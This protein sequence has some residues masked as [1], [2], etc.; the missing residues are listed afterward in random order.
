MKIEY[1][2]SLYFI[3]FLILTVAVRAVE[4]FRPILL[5]ESITFFVFATSLGL[6]LLL[7]LLFI[8]FQVLIDALFP[9]AILNIL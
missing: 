7:L 3:C 8:A 6:F 4:S 1:K 2:L 5:H 9:F